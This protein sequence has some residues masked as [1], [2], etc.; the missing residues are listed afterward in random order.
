[1]YFNDPYIIVEE[2]NITLNIYC[3]LSPDRNYTLNLKNRKYLT[4]LLCIS[5]FRVFPGPTQRRRVDKQVDL[6]PSPSLPD[7]DL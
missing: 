6:L 2:N 5:R 3:S 7:D 1:V 4:L